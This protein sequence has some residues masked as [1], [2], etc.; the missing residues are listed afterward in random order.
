[1][2]FLE[3]FFDKPCVDAQCKRTSY[4][5]LF[6][7]LWQTIVF[8]PFLPLSTKGK[9]DVAWKWWKLPPPI[10]KDLKDGINQGGVTNQPSN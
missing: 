5:E 1:M 4:S 3:Q 7:S 8:T 2:F 6:Q 10:F 9:M